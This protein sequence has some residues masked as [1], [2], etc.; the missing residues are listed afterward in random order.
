MTNITLHRIPVPKTQIVAGMRIDL[1]VFMTIAM[2][3]DE[4]V[5]AGG[6]AWG[7]GRCWLFLELN[8]PQTDGRFLL[9]REAK[10]LKR[11]AAQLGETEVYVARDRSFPTS[12]RL[13]KMLGFEFHA[14][15]QGEEVHIWRV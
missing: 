9:I 7:A 11:K 2:R 14:E 12:A 15:E 3:G 5:G 1:P 10:R 13:L 4:Y 8:E 6:L